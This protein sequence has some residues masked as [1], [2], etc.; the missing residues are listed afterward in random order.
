MLA[1]ALTVLSLF[2]AVGLCNLYEDVADLPG[3]QYDFVIIGGGTAGNALASRLTENP[4]V[5]VLVLEA[6]LN[7]GSDPNVAV[8]FLSGGVSANATIYSWNYTTIPQAGADG[9]AYPF[10]RAFMLG[11]CS[12][13]NGLAYTRGAD[14]D[15]DRYATI[16][17][18]SGW[19]WNSV[20]PYFKKAEQW[21]A[22][23][24]NHNTAGQYTP[25]VHGT[26]GPIQVSLAG[27]TWSEFQGHVLQTTKELPN[28]FP[29]NQDP[30]S[31][32]PLGIGYMQS[33][34]GNGARSSSATGYL[35]ST[36]LARSNL[37]VL[38]HAQVSK[39]VN[40]VASRVVPSEP[41]AFGGVQFRFDGTLY[42][43]N[44]TKEIILSAG[45]IGTPSILMHSGVG[46]SAVLKPLGIPVVRDLPSVGK[47]SSE[48]PYGGLQWPV[49]SN[50][51]IEALYSSTS[52]MDSSMAQWTKSRTGPMVDAP[53]GP[54][55]AWLRL[56]ANS[57]TLQKYPDPSSGA[58]APHFEVLFQPSGLD[59][60]G[61]GP[62]TPTVS[63]TLGLVS[64]A[65][66]GSVTINSADPFAAPVIDLGL[67]S[68]DFDASAFAEGLQLITKIAS[69]PNWK[70]Y[71][72]APVLD[73]S[74]MSLDDIIAHVRGASGPGYHF[75]G[76]AGMSPRGAQYGAVDP[77]LKVKGIYGLRVVDV[78]VLPV[79]P[80]AHTQAAAY[81]VA[82]RAAD[83]IKSQ[84]N[85]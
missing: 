11:G 16:S 24:D 19:S 85:L 78:S 53:P 29:F 75:V 18:D 34:I 70:G 47:N 46:D 2:S 62:Y 76:T 31:G 50:Q 49:T 60:Y 27:Y 81:V 72:G 84:W 44:A 12:A 23:S 79:V 5:A 28:E 10:S 37:H 54:M 8:P 30:N 14:S 59:I 73:I 82:E 57:T 40:P 74:T 63:L 55:L 56:P 61:P 69:A 83:L 4:N 43:A 64:P 6:G 45:P 80:A 13:H 48:H 7:P 17:G 26:S 52:V 9:I 39:L 25:S 41:T 15:W 58:D 3:F 77:D 22:P 1:P 71:L 33:T 32:K 65:S 20:L 66:R 36:V 67:F 51:T 35:N 42:V 38:L 21:T 68:N